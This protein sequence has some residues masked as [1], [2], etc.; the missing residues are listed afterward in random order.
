MCTGTHV[1]KHGNIATILPCK[2]DHLEKTHLLNPISA[3]IF[4]ML[5][6]TLTLV[7]LNPP[8]HTVLHPPSSSNIIIITIDHESH[9]KQQPRRSGRRSQKQLGLLLLMLLGWG[10]C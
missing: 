5:S 7:A 4:C 1:T 10:C 6:P 8:P 3:H 9:A 2:I